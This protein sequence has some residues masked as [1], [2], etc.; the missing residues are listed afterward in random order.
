MSRYHRGRG[1]RLS[2]ASTGEP[3]LTVTARITGVE[4]TSDQFKRAR[5]EFNSKMRDVIAAAG[6]R[7]VLPAIKARFPSRR[8]GASLFVRRDRTTVFIGSRMRGSLNRAVGWLDF[9]GKRPL[10]R[11][12]RI[13]PQVIVTEL[14]GRRHLIDHEVYVGLL[15]TFKPLETHP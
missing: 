8:F 15:Q 14:R 7:S 11:R 5:R 4:R 9:G 13:G 3:G 6:E 2:A 1:G 10:D 12:V